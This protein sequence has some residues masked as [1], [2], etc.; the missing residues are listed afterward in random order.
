MSTKHLSK[1]FELRSSLLSWEKRIGI[2]EFSDHKK[3]ILSL[4]SQ[5][6]KL[7]I[8]INVF[9][10]ND[11]IKEQMSEASFNRALKDL[12]ED[13]LISINKDPLDKRSLLITK[14]NL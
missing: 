13:N 4:L 10:S 12:V 7:P 9:K 5:I 11:F 3:I 1:I 2:D 14:I 8:S 6:K